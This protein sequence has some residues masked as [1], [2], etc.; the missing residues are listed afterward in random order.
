[1]QVTEAKPGSAPAVAQA[2]PALVPPSCCR[3]KATVL[4]QLQ[5]HRKLQA[6]WRH[7]L[8]RP[9]ACAGHARD[10]LYQLLICSCIGINVVLLACIAIRRP[11]LLP[12]VANL[13][14]SILA[15]A[16][17]AAAAAVLLLQCKRRCGNLILHGQLWCRRT[18]HP[19]LCV[20]ARTAAGVLKT[21]STEYRVCTCC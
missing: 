12:T 17:V 19:R 20:A 9:H 11:L 1:M 4:Q 3:M 13:A 18:S 8:P 7:L 21:P 6:L 10:W 5:Q 2:R 16:A 15:C 14:V